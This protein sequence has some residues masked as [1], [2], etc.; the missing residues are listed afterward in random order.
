M[1][2]SPYTGIITRPLYDSGSGRYYIKVDGHQ[3]KVPWR[4]GRVYQVECLNLKP[5]M[6]YDIG[7]EVEIH[8]KNS[9][10]RYILQRIQNNKILYHNNN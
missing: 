9:Q 6:D 1:I 10:G 5:I 3:I 8:F 7:E 4:Y 2:C